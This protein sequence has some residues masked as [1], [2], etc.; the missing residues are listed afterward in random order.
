MGRTVD[1][2]LRVGASC[3]G[4]VKRWSGLWR[5]GGL[6]L[7]VACWVWGTRGEDEEEK[8]CSREVKLLEFTWADGRKWRVDGELEDN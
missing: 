1:L 2:G 8:T 4:G 5:C 6:D 7:I 3:V